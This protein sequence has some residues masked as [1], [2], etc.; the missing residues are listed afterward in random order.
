MCRCLGP[1]RN[2]SKQEETAFKFPG[3]VTGA[4]VRALVTR[5]TQELLMPLT[6]FLLPSG[7]FETSLKGL[8]VFCFHGKLLATRS[9]GKTLEPS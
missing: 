8:R 4:H 9:Q 1:L 2:F 7:L 6:A 3:L 5:H